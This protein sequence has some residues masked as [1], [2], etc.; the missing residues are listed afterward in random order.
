MKVQ[1]RFLLFVAVLLALTFPAFSRDI[2]TDYD[3][4]ANFSQYKTLFV[5]QG[6]DAKSS[7]ERSHQGC[8]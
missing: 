5:G 6:R 8:G 2:K 4:H 7:V 3:H 1:F